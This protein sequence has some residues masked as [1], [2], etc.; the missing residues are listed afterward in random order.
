MTFEK[1]AENN[2]CKCLDNTSEDTKNKYYRVLKKG[3]AELNAQDLLTNYENNIK[4]KFDNCEGICSNRALSFEITNDEVKEVVL[5]ILRTKFGITPGLKSRFATLI[6]F[7][8]DAGKLKQSGDD[9]YHYDFYKDDNFDM[10]KVE[11][12]E[13]IDLGQQNEG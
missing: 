10:T 4:P 2:K 12:I 9:K 3:N 5:D 1:I 13:T 11:I 6:K 7:E 8:Q